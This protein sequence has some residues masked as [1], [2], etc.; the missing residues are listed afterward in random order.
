METALRWVP[1]AGCAISLIY[2]FLAFTDGFARDIPMF[3]TNK[4]MMSLAFA[5]TPY[6]AVK[7]FRDALSGRG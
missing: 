2:L 1:V 7:V 6:L 3:Q 4:A 5:V